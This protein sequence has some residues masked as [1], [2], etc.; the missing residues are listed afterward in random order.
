[1][2][3]PPA[4]LKDLTFG[5]YFVPAVLPLWISDDLKTNIEASMKYY[6]QYIGSLDLFGFDNVAKIANMLP[7]NLSK[8]A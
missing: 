5:N 2:R 1:M 6:R 4:E 7:Y 3:M 8:L